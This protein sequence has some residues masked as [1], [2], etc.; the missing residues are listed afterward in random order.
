MNIEITLHTWE[1]SKMKKVMSLFWVPCVCVALIGCGDGGGASAPATDDGAA[2]TS[3][4]SG[5]SEEA[6]AE[7]APAE[8]APAE[9]APAE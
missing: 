6:P 7:E 5:T 1:I 9:E 2:E 4:G 8:E 3:E